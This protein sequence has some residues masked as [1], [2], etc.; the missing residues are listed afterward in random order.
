[1]PLSTVA[2]VLLAAC[3]HAAWNFAIKR[4]QVDPTALTWAS[5]VVV[6][7]GWAPLVFWLHAGD[8]GAMMP[9]AWLAVAVSGVVHVTYFIVLQRGY[10]AADLSVVYPV[11]RGVGPLVASLAAIVLLGEPATPLSIAGLMAVVAGTF[12]VAGGTAMLRGGWSP[13]TAAGLGWGTATGVL[14]AA[15]TVNDG[16]A[17]RGLAAP[18]LLYYW[19]TNVAEALVLTPWALSHRDRAASVLR[20]DWRPV[21]WV[22]VLSPLAY[23]LVLVA[24]QSAPIS[25][26][27]PMREVSMLVAAFLGAKLLEE[28]QLR[29]RLGGAAMIA[30]GV[31]C[32]AMAK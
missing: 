10:Q 8:L 25:R 19:L 24:M 11:A 9:A 22:A 26:V 23:A 30:G 6:F 13:R 31:A 7:T 1:M 16:H 21:L 5:S 28:G 3:L 18:P 14:I 12:T 2:L 32:L 27:A 15:Y 4:A 17:V 29:R 20:R